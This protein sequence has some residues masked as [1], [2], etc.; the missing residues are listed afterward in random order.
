M[1]ERALEGACENGL[2]KA[3]ARSGL[4]RALVR[5]GAG[6]F[7]EL[8][9]WRAGQEQRRRDS[10]VRIGA[11]NSRGSAISMSAGAGAGGLDIPANGELE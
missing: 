1:Q 11:E 3:L 10:G 4:W 5:S 7:G 2:W 6:Q 9:R 8:R